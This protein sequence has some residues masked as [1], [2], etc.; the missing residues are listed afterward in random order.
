MKM[1]SLKNKKYKIIKNFIGRSTAIELAKEFEEYCDSNNI[2]GDDQVPG[3]SAVNNYIPFVEMLTYK[4]KEVSDALGESVLPTSCY[5]RVYKNGDVLERHTDKPHCEVSLSVHLY[6]DTEWSIYFGDDHLHLEPGDAVLYFGCDI[7]HGRDAY[8]GDK[9]SQVFLHYVRSRGTYSDRF[10]SNT[11]RKQL[12]NSSYIKVYDNII[13]NELCDQII[14]EFKD[15]DWK[16]SGIG[17]DSEIND[18]IRNCFSIAMYKAYVKNPTYRIELDK[19]IFHS[20]SKALQNYTADFANLNVVDDTGYDLL[21]YTEGQ[22]YVQHVDSFKDQNRALTCSLILNDDYEGGEFAFFDR[23][24]KFKLKKGQ[25][26]M[27]PSN[28]MFPHEI[29]PVKSGTR[30]SIITWFV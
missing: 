4:A 20:M 14:E 11:Q 21:R 16:R 24:M 30:Y 3:S 7:S 8:L 23:E 17:K 10:F 5:A 2:Q 6:G 25:A 26:I 22:F 18:E 1:N 19:K 15:D 9:Y 13:S 27:F 29:L 12:N 28:F